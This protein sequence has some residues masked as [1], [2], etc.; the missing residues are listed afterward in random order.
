MME[1]VYETHAMTTDNEAGLATGWLPGR[2]SEQGRADARRLGERRRDDEIELVVT[3]DLRRAVE[4]AEIAFAGSEIPLRRDRR[5]RECDYGELNGRPVA[6]ID[7]QRVQR[8]DRPFAGGESYR[9]V[10]ARPRA[11]SRT[12]CQRDRHGFS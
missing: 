8:V 2:L 5:L 9:D 11:S 4:T 7:A 10:V 6:E 3:S 1:L 12:C